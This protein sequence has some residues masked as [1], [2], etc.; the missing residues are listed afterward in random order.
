MAG[1]HVRL[2]AVRGH[3]QR[4]DQPQTGDEANLRQWIPIACAAPTPPRP[5]S[6]PRRTAATPSLDNRRVCTNAARVY[7][8]HSH[9]PWQAPRITYRLPSN[10]STFTMPYT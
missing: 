10:R 4:D 5:A 6:R 7:L 1:A 8:S 3:G 2:D 9:L